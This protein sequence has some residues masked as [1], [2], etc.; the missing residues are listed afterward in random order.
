LSRI[1]RI[2][3]PDAPTLDLVPLGDLAWLARF[4]TESDARRWA[5]SARRA[6]LAGVVDVVL[7]YKSASVHFDPDRVDGD[8]LAT[9]LRGLHPDEEAIEAGRL[10]TLPVLYD[11]EDLPEVAA[12]LGLTTYEVIG[13]H[14]GTTYDVFAIGFQPGFPYAGYLPD[15]LARLP[16]RAE[17]RLRVPSGSVAIAAG[18]TGVYPVELPGGW[19][20]IGR[21]PLSIVDVAADRFPIRA[22]DRLAFTPIDAAEFARRLGEPLI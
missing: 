3:P 7:A 11:G 20:L 18:Q 17:P 15:P 1:P 22:G 5:L 10:I 19:N 16:R 14:S 4:A 13:I 21:T 12:L 8:E 2:E 9:S 6:G